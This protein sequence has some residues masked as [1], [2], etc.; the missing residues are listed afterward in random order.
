[1]AVHP[2]ASDLFGQLKADAASVAE[3]M[4]AMRAVA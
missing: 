4:A 1:M 2:A 3:A